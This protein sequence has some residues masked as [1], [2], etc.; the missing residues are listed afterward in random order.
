MRIVHF[1]NLAN[2]AYSIVKGLRRVRIEADVVVMKYGAITQYPHWEE[3]TTGVP[4]KY[5]V[6]DE[7]FSRLMHEW[8]PPSWVR[9]LDIGYKTRNIHEILARLKIIKIMKE[10]DLVVAHMPSS[11]YAMLAK[12]RYIPF[13]AGF[14]R[15]IT[16]SGL[17]QK[18]ALKSYISAPFIIYTNPDTINIFKSVKLDNRIVFC[19]FAI[20]TDKYSPSTKTPND[21]PTII[22]CPSRHIWR[23]KGNHIALYA[24]AE[25]QKKFNPEAELHL[26]R[27]GE[28]LYR[29]KL[30]IKK[31]GIKNV[32]WHSVMPKP[33]LIDLYR[34]SD[35]VLDQFVLGSYGTSAPEAMSCEKPV[36]VYLD[37]DANRNA[38]GEIPPVINVRTPEEILKALSCLD[39][40]K[41]QDIGRKG[42]EWVIRKHSLEIVTKI[43]V[44]LYRKLGIL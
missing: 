42:R 11:I 7:D 18:L 28:D 36:F 10:Y 33:K 1:F 24:F 41:M 15:Y 27:W 39:R 23:E 32:V 37:K 30:L 38:F 16:G 8:N 22:F 12:V 20:D 21:I 34:M 35:V 9:F 26:C 25:F 5:H 44:E 4:F 13:D 29:T 40:K 6:S 2:D 31:L 19:P 17:K 14:I 43:H 3:V